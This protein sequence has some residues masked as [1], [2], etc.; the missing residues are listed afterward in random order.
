MYSS[1]TWYIHPAPDPSQGGTMLLQDCT[2]T[3]P[4][5]RVTEGKEQTL[6]IHLV[7]RHFSSSEIAFLQSWYLVKSHKRRKEKLLPSNL[8]LCQHQFS[9]SGFLNTDYCINNSLLHMIYTL[10]LPFFFMEQDMFPDSLPPS[11]Y[12]VLMTCVEKSSNPFWALTNL[13]TLSY[14]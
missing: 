11:N 9:N 14:F 12:F 13:R 4:G 7:G 10:S 1:N 8:P 6:K 2:C 5:P 3:L